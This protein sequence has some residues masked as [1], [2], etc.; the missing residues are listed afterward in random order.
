MKT[1]GSMAAGCRRP[2]SLFNYGSVREK[3]VKVALQKKKLEKDMT[4]VRS[5]H[6]EWCGIVLLGSA[7]LRDTGGFL[8][9]Q[10]E[11]KMHSV[12]GCK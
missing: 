10:K 7:S 5:K 8:T 12:S 11:A 4:F 9:I 3:R 6:L 1:R 2:R